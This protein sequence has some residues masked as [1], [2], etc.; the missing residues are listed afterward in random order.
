M[1]LFE[2]IHNNRLAEVIEPPGLNQGFRATNGR[3]DDGLRWLFYL[4]V[5]RFASC[6]GG[7]GRGRTFRQG[8]GA[9]IA[10]ELLLL[11]R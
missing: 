10:P 3:I 1:S 9:W 2:D 7:A 5:L 4:S 8:N 6:F 11:R